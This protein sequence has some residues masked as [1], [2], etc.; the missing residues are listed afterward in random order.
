MKMRETLRV[1]VLTN[2]AGF[3][4]L[5]L[6]RCLH[7]ELNQLLIYVC[8]STERGRDWKNEWG[9]LPVRV[10]KCWTYVARQRY[11]ALAT[12]VFYRHIPY[13]T[14]P[15][16]ISWRPHVVVSTE[17]GFR[18]M[19]AA[20]YRKAFPDSRLIIWTG[21][22][23]HTEERV[24]RWR[25]HQRKIFFRAA[26]AA[27]ANGVSARAYLLSLGVPEKKIFGLPYC[28][29]LTPYLGMPLTREP[30]AMR[31]LLYV[32]QLIERK[33]L[34]P[35]VRLLSDWVQEHPEYRW[36][37]QIAGDGPLRSQIEG[38]PIPSQL[39]LTFL[40]S[41]AREDLA[42]VYA[43]AGIV[44]FPTLADEWG[45]VVNE[46]LAAGVPVLGSVYSQAVEELVKDGETGWVFRPDHA[47]EVRRA[48]D[49][50]LLAPASQLTG[51]RSK[52]RQ[53]VGHLT[54]SYGAN[55]L[56]RAIRF[57]QTGVWDR[58]LANKPMGEP[59]ACCEAA[60]VT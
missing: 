59:A 16:L 21:L 33:G 25:T 32:G 18:T 41:V 36:E 30:G 9:E 46:A 28:L 19:Q 39:R 44:I 2:S 17:L 13:D 26:D 1:C 54:P 7:H 20:L 60:D 5:P 55:Q 27:S 3:D 10:R 31:R 15:L 37:L 4:E 24:P 11:S 42:S 29:D 23:Q 52:C 6:L 22:S 57:V 53:A 8:T 51:M 56:L 50:A 48:L 35:F 12:E 34:G 49:R 45:L 43:K 38:I 47:E 58:A 40:G 14:I